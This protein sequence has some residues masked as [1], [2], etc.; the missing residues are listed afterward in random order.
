MAENQKIPKYNMNYSR[1]Q[2]NSPVSANRGLRAH[3]IAY[4]AVN[5]FLMLLNFLTSDFSYGNL[6]FLYPLL[7]WGIGIFIHTSVVYIRHR[8]PYK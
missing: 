1:I 7:G 8:F 3:W 5:G 2:G 6:W 4:I